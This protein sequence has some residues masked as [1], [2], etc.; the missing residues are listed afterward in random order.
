MTRKSATRA[1]LES[2]RRSR[3]E[4]AKRDA[5]IRGLPKD[6]IYRI[7]REATTELVR[8][9]IAD[10]VVEEYRGPNG[11]RGIRPTAQGAKELAMHAPQVLELLIRRGKLSL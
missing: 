5:A 1:V 2:T 11:E 10:G 9:L 8:A 3:L 6:E 7:H 4:Q